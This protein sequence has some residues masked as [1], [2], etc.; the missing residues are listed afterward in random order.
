MI[1]MNESKKSG[2]S[3]TTLHR[4]A[5]SSRLKCSILCQNLLSFSNCKEEINSKQIDNAKVFDIF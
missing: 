1:P 3:W 4:F 2:S 5:S